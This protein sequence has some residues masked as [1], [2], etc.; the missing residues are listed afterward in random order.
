MPMQYFYSLSA[1]LMLLG[2]MFVAQAILMIKDEFVVY[3]MV[4]QFIG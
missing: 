3:K 4:G 2:N 1:E